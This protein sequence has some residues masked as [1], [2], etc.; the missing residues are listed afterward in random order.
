[1]DVTNDVIVPDIPDKSDTEGDNSKEM[2]MRSV[3]DKIVVM[4]IGV[5][6]D[7]LFLEK[8]NE[9]LGLSTTQQLTDLVTLK[10]SGVYALLSNPLVVGWNITIKVV[11]L[12][13]W[14]ESPSWYNE[15]VNNLGGRMDM[16]CRSTTDKP[17]D[18]IFLETANT[19]GS[20]VG[21]SWLGTMCNPRWRCSIGKG[22]NLNSW[23]EAHETG[24]S[25]GLNHD[26]TFTTCDPNVT[27]GFM[28]MKETIFR[29]C[30]GPVLDSSLSSKTCLFE[31]NVD[32]S[33]YNRV[34][35]IAPLY[36][37]QLLGLDGQCKLVN[38]EGSST[39]IV[40]R[41]TFV[42]G[43]PVYKNRQLEKSL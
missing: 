39:S 11:H 37:G 29:D 36:R 12:E 3:Q 31:E 9:S 4:E 22:V 5:Y 27:S 33:M 19:P 26:N 30:Y 18:H 38:G 15:T 14:R 17:F 24:H 6:L 13:I 2:R 32:N 40:H 16:I 43:L 1:M 25:M 23:I 34:N 8:I 28:S 7:R 20:T 42:I 10:W 21:L 41:L 35:N